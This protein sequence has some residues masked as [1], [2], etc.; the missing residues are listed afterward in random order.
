MFN[1]K[2]LLP[3]S[4][5]KNCIFHS[6]RHSTYLPYLHFH[7]TGSARNMLFSH[8]WALLPFSFQISSFTSGS[9]MWDNFPN[10]LPSQRPLLVLTVGLIGAMKQSSHR[11]PIN[12]CP[13]AEVYKLPIYNMQAP[14]PLKSFDAIWCESGGG[15]YEK[16][17]REKRVNWERS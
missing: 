8:K 5:H 17:R 15:W 16:R 13:L 1:S 14:L 11:W 9:Q 7:P 10:S 12:L 2:D 4:S 3:F 6:Y